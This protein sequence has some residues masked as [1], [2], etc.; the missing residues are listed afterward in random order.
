MDDINK[1]R[2]K[3]WKNVYIAFI[4]NKNTDVFY[5]KTA[6]NKALEE[7][8]KKFENDINNQNKQFIDK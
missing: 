5:A 7:F 6:S 2:R 8:D 1:E 4:N 3:F